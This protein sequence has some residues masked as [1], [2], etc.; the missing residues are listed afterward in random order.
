MLKSFATF[1]VLICPVN[2]HT[3]MPHGQAEDMLD[4]TYTMT[5]NLTGW[6]SVVI[7]CGLDEAGLPIG[8]Q[9][10]AAPFREDQ[11]LALAEWI[12]SEL[13]FFPLPHVNSNNLA[14]TLGPKTT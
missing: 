10:I 13:D 6:P 7:P 8:L 5:Y 9:L 3:A 2:A 12:Q 14:L 11:C 1:D 4:Y